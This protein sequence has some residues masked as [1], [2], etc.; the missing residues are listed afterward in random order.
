MFAGF[1]KVNGSAGCDREQG[2]L[3]IDIAKRC[4]EFSHRP[5]K[6]KEPKNYLDATCSKR[7]A[8]HHNIKY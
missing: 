6:Q 8:A 1:S 7:V 2:I 3:Y 5:Y 4:H